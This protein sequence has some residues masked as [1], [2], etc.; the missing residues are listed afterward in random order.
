ML[1]IQGAPASVHTRK[2][3]LAARE[4]GLAYAITPVVPFAPPPGWER[5]SPTGKIPVLIDGDLA[6]ADSSAICAYIERAYP[7]PALYPKNAKA[8][9]HAL[10][11]EAYLGGTFYPQTIH[12]L[13]FEQ[14]IGPK[15]KGHVTD[16]GQVRRI[17]QE[18][19][20]PLFDYLETLTGSEFLA[21]DAFSIA[22]ISLASNLI[23][24]HY[25]GHRLDGTRHAGLK[26]AFDR[27]LR[28]PSIAAALDDEREFARS[29]GLDLS[30]SLQS[31]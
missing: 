25:L 21:G 4:K 12:P 31:A 16:A 1:Q 17:V 19:A 18:V 15:A 6:L 20:P 26:A 8:L 28:R 30:F 13:F 27:Y 5:L 22:D 2:V 11:I 29:M 14:V 9:G 7:E 3:V 23:N 24:F 10:W